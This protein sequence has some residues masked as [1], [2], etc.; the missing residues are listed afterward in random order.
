MLAQQWQQFFLSLT[1]DGIVLPLVD[2]GLHP[3]VLV[4]P[5]LSRTDSNSSTCATV[6]LDSPIFHIL[7]QI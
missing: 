5:F 3:A 7:A 1:A 6:E 4:T 2:C